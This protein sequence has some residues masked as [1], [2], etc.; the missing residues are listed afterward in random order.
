ML[1]SILLGY[2]GAGEVLHQTGLQSYTLAAFGLSA[3]I[4]TLA[5]ASIDRIRKFDITSFWNRG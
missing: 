4:V 2:L 3:V 5:L 1:V